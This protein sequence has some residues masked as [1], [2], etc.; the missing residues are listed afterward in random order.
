MLIQVHRVHRVHG[1]FQGS[2][3]GEPLRGRQAHGRSV[4]PP[5]D[6]N[7]A[8]CFEVTLRWKHQSVCL[9]VF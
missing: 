7:G 2:A 8:A 5:T 4:E 6:L 1:T 9:C 3:V